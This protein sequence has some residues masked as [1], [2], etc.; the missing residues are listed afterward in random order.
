MVDEAWWPLKFKR[1]GSWLRA[2]IE[3]P[4]SRHVIVYD[5]HEFSDLIEAW[6]GRYHLVIAST[7]A[8]QHACH[9]GMDTLIEVRAF[10]I[11]LAQ[12][13]EPTDETQRA[14]LGT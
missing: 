2:D 1:D 7:G 4:R 10:L 6:G 11:H 9:V 5:N 13:Q 12:S 3:Y 8:H 14:A